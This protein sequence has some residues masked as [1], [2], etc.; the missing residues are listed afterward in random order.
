[1]GQF[2]AAGG[3]GPLSGDFDGDGNDDY[4]RW[5]RQYTRLTP[6]P[7]PVARLV[8][9]RTGAVLWSGNGEHPAAVG[10][11]DLD[12]TIDLARRGW[13]AESTSV[14]IVSGA[15]GQTLFE[16]GFPTPGIGAL[17]DINGDGGT[18]LLLGNQVMVG[19]S[20]DFFGAPNAQLIGVTHN[21]ALSIAAPPVHGGKPYWILGSVSGTSPGVTVG[22]QVVP[23][24]VDP[25]TQHTIAFPGGG[26]LT[27]NVGVL[28]AG[29]AAAARMQMPPLP[30]AL[31]GL[32]IHHTY[33]VLG[34]TSIDYVSRPVPYALLR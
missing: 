10:D 1:M 4:W 30:S 17:G 2:P 8:S 31:A 29:G 25:Y 21:Q 20:P 22:N 23:L 7:K 32:T 12:G 28:N 13:D 19:S 26:I 16:G 5:D 15:T 33:V 3:S 6:Y 11:L 27:G 9:G 18:D 24:N 14:A 34:A